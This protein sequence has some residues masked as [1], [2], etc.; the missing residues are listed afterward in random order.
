M[1]QDLYPALNLNR[2][3]VNFG[4]FKPRLKFIKFHLRSDLYSLFKLSES[5]NNLQSNKTFH[6]HAKYL[7]IILF[8]RFFHNLKLKNTLNI[9]A[10]NSFHYLKLPY[11]AFYV[12]A[13][14]SIH[15][16]KLNKTFYCYLT[17]TNFN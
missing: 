11:K 1:F 3:L 17:K 4:G 5:S 16:L 15:N 12:I 6:F 8:S 13:K 7:N 9:I 14:K 10:K 2:V